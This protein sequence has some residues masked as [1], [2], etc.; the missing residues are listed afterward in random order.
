MS[1]VALAQVTLGSSASSVTFSNIPA[2]YRDLVLVIAGT[3]SGDTNPRLRLNGDTGNASWVGMWGNGSSTTS[4]ANTDALLFGSLGTSQSNTILQIMDYSAS[5]K[6]K[7][8]LGRGN[9]GA[10]SVWA[11]A[12]RWASTTVVNSA[13]IVPAIGVNFNTGTTFNLFGIRA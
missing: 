12:G 6:H 7:T 2:T 5:D 1:Y 10:G 11:F 4:A 3:T 13:T 9:Q 8:V